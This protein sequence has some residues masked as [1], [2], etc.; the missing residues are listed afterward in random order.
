MRTLLEKRRLPSGDRF[1][2]EDV[3]GER[4]EGR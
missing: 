1:D 4:G 3:Y 2:R